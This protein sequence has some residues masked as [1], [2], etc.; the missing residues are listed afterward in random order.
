MPKVKVVRVCHCESCTA[1]G[2]RALLDD[3]IDLLGEEENDDDTIAEP[4]LCSQA[5]GNPPPVVH[6]VMKHQ[7]V[8]YPHISTYSALETFFRGEF[9]EKPFANSTRNK[10]RR[11]K[12]DYRREQN[13]S[14]KEQL[15]GDA[16]R[17]ARASQRAA[18]KRAGST[19]SFDEGHYLS[20]LLVLRS[21]LRMEKP[22]ASESDFSEA[23]ADARQA[24]DLTPN[25]FEAGLAAAEAFEAVSD[26]VSAISVLDKVMSVMSMPSSIGTPV[27]LDKQ[28]AIA[29]RR[30]DLVA[31]DYS[32]WRVDC[33]EVLERQCKFVLLTLSAMDAG[34]AP[35]Q[36]FPSDL[37][38]IRVKAR[39]EMGRRPVARPYTPISS[40][41]EYLNGKLSLLVKVYEKGR[42]SKHLAGVEPGTVLKVSL[43]KST[44][45]LPGCER[46][47]VCVVGGSG[48]TAGLQLAA[49]ASMRYKTAPIRLVVC[50]DAVDDLVLEKEL[51]ELLARSICVQVVVYVV[52]GIA[53]GKS[54]VGK[55]YW[56][57]GYITLSALTMEVQ[58]MVA[59]SGPPGL[60]EAVKA[61]LP[62]ADIPE[63][64]FINLDTP[65]VPD[66]PNWLSGVT[67]TPGSPRRR[68]SSRRNGLKRAAATRMAKRA[69]WLCKVFRSAS[70]KSVHSIDPVQPP[71]IPKTESP[72]EKPVFL[73][74]PSFHVV[75]KDAALTISRI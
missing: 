4:A 53:G 42:M 8:S 45:E 6:V 27:P 7:T 58:T 41:E 59:V 24:L 55:V 70:G 46:G 74:C 31:S 33:A 10:S 3:I 37:W 19:M 73:R 69:R 17:T 1:A 2:A 50:I 32:N 29:W 40:Q 34:A 47:M 65:S 54:R 14:Q 63:A 64:H 11:L 56:R 9:G 52:K 38:H 16:V 28:V 57:S 49:A 68:N 35:L 66:G 15:L 71:A 61:M 39:T 20:E 5:C 18:P 13:F 23:L 62:E 44:C 43:P 12:F 60:C 21:R 26:D 30:S 22:S 75:Q 25:S 67:E 36:E 51:L 72:P 48:I